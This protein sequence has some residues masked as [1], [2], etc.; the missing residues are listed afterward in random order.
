MS[1]DPGVT[2]IRDL[3]WLLRAGVPPR[4]ALSLVKLRYALEVNR[5]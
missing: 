5:R 4:L 1:P 3:T 2:A